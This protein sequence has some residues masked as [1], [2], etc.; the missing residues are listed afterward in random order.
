MVLLLLSLLTAGC[1]VDSNNRVPINLNHAL[2]LVDSVEVNER[3]L[4]YIWIYADAPDYSHTIAQGEGVTCVDDVGRF[5]E[6]LEYSILTDKRTELLPIA[7]GMTYFLLRMVREDGLWYNFMFEDGTINT[8]HINSMPEFSWWAVRGLRGLASAYAIFDGTGVEQELQEKIKAA[9]HTSDQ[10]IAK[11]LNKYPEYRVTAT[12]KLP[13]WLLNGAPDQTSELMLALIKLQQ[14]GEFDYLDEIHQFGQGLVGSQFRE[15]GHKLDGM[16]FCWEN[17][18]HGWANNHALA[19]VEAYE[20]THNEDFR[21][22]VEAWAQNFVPYLIEN[23][24]PRRITIEADLSF[25]VH[26]YPQI[27]YGI[28]STYR[29]ILKWSDSAGTDRDHQDAE[30]VLNWFFGENQ[31]GEFIYDQTSGRCFDGINSASAINRNSGAESTIEC[32]LALQAFHQK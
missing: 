3:M 22:S 4:H 12:G 7:K 8:D 24:F 5:L 15:P 6:V 31:L 16:Y 23:K 9:I 32:L 18:W 19:L 26:Q 13:N 2:S 14:T 20:L 21:T 28:N 10:H 25:E 1:A 17:V 27:A 30:T 29:G 11:I